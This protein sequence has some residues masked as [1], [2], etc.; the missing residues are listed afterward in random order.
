MLGDGSVRPVIDPQS[1]VGIA[2]P[3]N[4]DSEVW[5]GN[6]LLWALSDGAG[7]ALIR[8][9]ELRSSVEVRFDGG[10]MPAAEK[11]LDPT[12]KTALNGGWFD[13]PGYVRLRQPGCYGFQ[14]EIANESFVIVISAA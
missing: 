8:G 11:V 3:A 6:K 14:V 2:P 9:R 5:G 1:P 12:G 13:F 10:V 4:F 7:V